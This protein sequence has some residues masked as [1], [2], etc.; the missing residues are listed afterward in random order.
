MVSPRRAPQP[1]ATPFRALSTPQLRAF[2]LIRAREGHQPPGA[3]GLTGRGEEERRS[4]QDMHLTQRD[5]TRAMAS[6]TLL[7]LAAR[8]RSSVARATLLLLEAPSRRASQVVPCIQI[9]RS[10]A[11]SAPRR[12]C[13][14]APPASGKAKLPGCRLV[15]TTS[16]SRPELSSSRSTKSSLRGPGSVR[17][18]ESAVGDSCVRACACR[19]LRLP[20]TLTGV[21]SSFT[22]EGEELP[23]EVR[24]DELRLVSMYRPPLASCG[25]PGDVA[26]QRRLEGDNGDVGG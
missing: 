20:E 12:R 3:E 21:R 4:P 24:S 8:P 18:G 2:A 19:A 22:A 23:V 6:A 9:E 15:A 10:T 11:A 7:C 14:A 16:V 26:S 25:L 5:A 17:A 13:A 1:S